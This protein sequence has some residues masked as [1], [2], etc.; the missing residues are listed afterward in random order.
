MCIRDRVHRLP[1]GN[2]DIHAEGLEDL[3][4]AGPGGDGNEAK[5]LCGLGGTVLVGV[6]LRRAFGDL[7]VHVMDEDLVDLAK[8]EHVLERC[9]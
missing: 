2:D 9:V 6:N 7:K 5:G 1:T 3:R 4:L 8:L